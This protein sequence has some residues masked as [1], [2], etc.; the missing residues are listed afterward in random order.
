VANKTRLAAG[1]GWVKRGASS[2]ITS[3]G[4]LLS[5]KVAVGL[6][7]EE[8]EKVGQVVADVVDVLLSIDELVVGGD[9]IASEKAVVGGCVEAWRVLST[10]C[11]YRPEV[12]DTHQGKVL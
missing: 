11:S 2:G 1:Q 10:D 9:A 12:T 3:N 4:K 7:S 6:E 8:G 5:N